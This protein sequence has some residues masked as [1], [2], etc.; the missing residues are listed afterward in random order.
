MGQVFL[1]MPVLLVAGYLSLGAAMEN[2]RLF[3]IAVNRVQ[4]LHL[5]AQK[6]FN[7][8][9]GTL[10]PD[11]RRQLNKIFLL[12][13]CNSDS[14]VSPIDKHETQKSSVLKLLHISFRLIESWEY[15][16]QTLT[17][18]MSN[19]LNQNQMSEKLSNLKVGINLLI[20]GNQEDVPSLDDND[21]QQLLPYGNY[22]QN[23]GDNDNVRR[24]YE[25]LAC[26]KKDMHKV[27]TYLTVAKCR[28]SLEANCTL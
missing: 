18:T 27:E 8:F 21:S 22:Y 10:L 25:L 4:H 26:F 5:L 16:S 23:L 1:L 15:P 9:E 6:M 11:E 7:D 2:Q 12:D 14:I 20:K 17:H 24:N 19:N 13:F 3:N 28:K